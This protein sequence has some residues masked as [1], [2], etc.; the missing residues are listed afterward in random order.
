M[1]LSSTSIRRTASP[2]MR[3][4][5]IRSTVTGC[6]VREE[7]VAGVEVVRSK[8]FLLI[9]EKLMTNSSWRLQTSHNSRGDLGNGQNLNGCPQFRRSLR[10]AIHNAGLTILRQRVAACATHA[11]Q[12]LGAIPP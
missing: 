4:S 12:S 10:H 1:S 11:E 9:V 8:L 2:I 5:S 3:W 6:S 7:L